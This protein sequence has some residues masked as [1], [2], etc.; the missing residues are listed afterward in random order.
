MDKPFEKI[1][2]ANRGEI[3]VRIIRGCHEMGIRTVA[4]YSDADRAA[5][6]VRFAHEAYR[7]GAAASSNE[8]YL[9]IDQDPRRG[10]PLRSRGDSPR[11]RFPGRERRPSP[12]P[13]AMRGL[14]FIG[15]PPEAMEAR[16]ATR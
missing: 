8:S 15:P 9:D 6:H 10:A 7:L 4:V 13:A 3:A 14:T 16:W 1:L 12:E 2:I 11:L 5:L